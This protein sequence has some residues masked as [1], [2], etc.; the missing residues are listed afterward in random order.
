[1]PRFKLWEKPKEHITSDVSKLSRSRRVARRV[2]GND[3]SRKDK[4]KYGFNVH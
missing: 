1:M 2:D 4:L 3:L